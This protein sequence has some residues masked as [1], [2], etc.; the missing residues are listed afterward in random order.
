[1]KSHDNMAVIMSVPNCPRTQIYTVPQI[2]GVDNPE[3][4]RNLFQRMWRQSH[5]KTTLDKGDDSCPFL[6][7]DKN[8]L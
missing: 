7:H 1:M 8:R 6:H 4:L 5:P 2:F 3:S